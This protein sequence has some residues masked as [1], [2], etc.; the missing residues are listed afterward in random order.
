MEE[1]LDGLIRIGAGQP[2]LYSGV[3]VETAVTM[4]ETGQ[5]AASA[6]EEALAGEIVTESFGGQTSTAWATATAIAGDGAAEETAEE[7]EREWTPEEIRRSA[8]LFLEQRR[9]D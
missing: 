3:A 4:E 8:E 1:I 7:T 2:V 6:E 5:E 9:S